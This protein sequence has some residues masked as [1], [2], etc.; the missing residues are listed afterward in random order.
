MLKGMSRMMG[1][2]AN[3]GCHLLENGKSQ[4]QLTA[5]TASADICRPIFFSAS[6][7]GQEFSPAAPI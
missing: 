2:Q 6:D 3:I 7:Y 5:G 4:E 1:C